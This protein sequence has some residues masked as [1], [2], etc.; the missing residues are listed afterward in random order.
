MHPTD[1]IHRI[2]PMVTL[3]IIANY[4]YSTWKKRRYQLKYKLGLKFGS[5]TI[6]PKMNTERTTLI[7]MRISN[8]DCV[9]SFKTYE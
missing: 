7:T 2:F 9:N 1:T 4:I 3:V 6:T 5:T 8:G